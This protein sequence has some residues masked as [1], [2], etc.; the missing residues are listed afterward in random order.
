M[1]S[2]YN[3]KPEESYRYKNI[4]KILSQRVKMQGFISG[5]F[6][7]DHYNE[8]KRKREKEKKKDD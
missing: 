6:A 4:S 1:I 8:V 2:Q 7:K 3:L 5:D